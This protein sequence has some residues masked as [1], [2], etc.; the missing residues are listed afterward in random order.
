MVIGGLG[1]LTAAEYWIA[2][3]VHSSPL[4]YLAPIALIKA[5]LIVQY[6]MHVRQLWGEEEVES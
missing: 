4:L 3:S 2:L 1:A 6:F 5:W